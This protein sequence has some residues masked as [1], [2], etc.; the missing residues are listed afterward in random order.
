VVCAVV[1]H[2]ADS[3][4]LISLCGKDGMRGDSVGQIAQ[5]VGMKSFVRKGLRKGLRGT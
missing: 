2:L 5:E 3:E 1:L 4:S